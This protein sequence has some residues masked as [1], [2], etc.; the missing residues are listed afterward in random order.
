MNYTQREA[1]R[2]RQIH[3]RESRNV[4]QM[5][6]SYV[7]PPRTDDVGYAT[8]ADEQTRRMLDATSPPLEGWNSLQIIDFCVYASKIDTEDPDIQSEL[9]RVR[10]RLFEILRLHIN[11][12]GGKARQSITLAVANC[13]AANPPPQSALTSILPSLPAQAVGHWKMSDLHAAVRVFQLGWN[14]LTFDSAVISA[15]RDMLTQMSNLCTFEYDCPS[16]M[17][18]MPHMVADGQPSAEFGT[19]VMTFVGEVL[20]AFHRHKQFRFS[21][22]NVCLTDEEVTRA[23][24]WFAGVFREHDVVTEFRQQFPRWMAMPGCFGAFAAAGSELPFMDPV[25]SGTT[26]SSCVRQIFPGVAA[27]VNLPDE[28]FAG[29]LGS[30]KPVENA[31]A[32][33]LFMWMLD[34]LTAGHKKRVGVFDFFGGEGHDADVVRIAGCFYIRDKKARVDGLLPFAKFWL[35]DILNCKELCD[36][37]FL[38]GAY[39]RGQ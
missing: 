21:R 31:C 27:T 37:I 17:L 11:T 25:P 23:K 14:T 4:R 30:H 8:A 9:A 2:L 3:E 38:R 1:K 28:Q 29:M 12:S 5:V 7:P 18:D 16:I 20:C 32:D 34:Y 10:T 39:R 36:D 13:C 22:A 33:A 26:K 24:Q 19:I 15:A 35:G 6:M